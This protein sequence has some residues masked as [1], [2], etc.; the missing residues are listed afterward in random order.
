VESFIAMLERDGHVTSAHGDEA[1]FEAE[2]AFGRRAR[3]IA[4]AANS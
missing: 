3:K 1:D 4:Q 2:L